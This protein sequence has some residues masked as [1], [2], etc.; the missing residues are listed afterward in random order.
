MI[1]ARLLKECS[2]EIAPILATIFNKSLQTDTVPADWKQANVSAVFKKG[3]RYDQSNYRPVSL[4]CLCCK[5]LE[6]DCQQCDEACGPTLNPH[7]LSAA[8]DRGIQADTVILDFSRAFDCVPHQRLLHKLHHFGIRGHLHKWIS[9]F[10][11]GRKQSV[12]VEGVASEST[13]VANRVPQG[14]VLQSQ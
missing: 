14:S 3:Q 11:K 6:R 10:L 9:S 4:T 7:R 13:P 5:L 1:P 12:I 2:K 8:M